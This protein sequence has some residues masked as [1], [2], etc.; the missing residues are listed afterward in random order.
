MQQLL[1]DVVP[2]FCVALA[3]VDI[4][5]KIALSVV[6]LL[7]TFFSRSVMVSGLTFKSLIHFGFILVCGVRKGLFS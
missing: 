6:S 7:P 2:F 5:K 4:A 1:F 3:R